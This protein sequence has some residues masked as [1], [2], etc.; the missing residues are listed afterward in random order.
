[1]KIKNII[2]ISALI[3]S[4][5]IILALFT[6]YGNKKV[7]PDLNAMML[8]KFMERNN[9]G[10]FSQKEF[11]KYSFF[12]EQ[13]SKLKGLGVIKEGLFSPNDVAAA[14]VVG[15]VGAVIDYNRGMNIYCEEGSAEMT[16]QGWIAHGGL[17]ADVPEVPASLRHFYD[18]TRNA[19]DRY[20][21]DIANS[22]LMGSLQKYALTNP[23]TDGVEWAI[24]QPGD[25][26]NDAQSHQFTWERGK[27]WMQMALQEPK[28]EK[29]NEYMAKAWRSLGETLHMIAD[30]GCP[31]HVRNDAHPS[32][33]LENDTWFGDADPYEELVDIIR[34]DDQETFVSFAS[35][36]PDADLKN[37]I[38]DMK[39]VRDLAHAL[40]EYTNK[41][42]V[43]NQTIAGIDKY[44]NRHKQIIHPEN[45]YDSPLLQQMTY[46]EDDYSYNSPSGIKQC[47]DHYYFAK[48]PVFCNPYVDVECVKSQASKLFPNIVE[49]GSKVIGLFIP[50]LKVEIK[51]VNGNSIKGNIIHT[52]D[53]EYQ[54]EIKYS[55]NLTLQLKNNK[56]KILQELNVQASNGKF[57]TSGISMSSEGAFLTAYIDFGGV[58]VQSDDFP[59]MPKIKEPEPVKAISG[60][61]YLNRVLIY[62]EGIFDNTLTCGGYTNS[63]KT[64]IDI[65]SHNIPISQGPGKFRGS[66]R[67]GNYFVEVSGT[68]TQDELLEFKYKGTGT[69]GCREQEWDIELRNIPRINKE[70]DSPNNAT[71]QLRPYNNIDW[72]SNNVNMADHVPRMV[73]K[74][75]SLE[76]KDQVRTLIETSW[77]RIVM[78]STVNISPKNQQSALEV[79]F[80]W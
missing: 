36:A 64:W 59:V 71:F 76:K 80:S 47:V 79:S 8:K 78:G 60:G 23:H 62:V 55:G 65:E 48:L 26:S 41:N 40:A 54:N 37:K 6:G 50:K 74:E 45:E 2:S 29:R 56:Y 61:A 38:K 73:L 24:G 17:A 22:K 28:V 15:D 77:G 9:K 35:G 11:R 42:F 27:L 14:G 57:E 1:M 67:F 13:E 68:F 33:V 63:E 30:N 44:G 25:R 21:T 72:K 19:G 20:L 66:K 43:T 7:H 46:N 16:P 39:K 34:R 58:R 12:F 10:D 31:P 69:L 51:S 75:T 4:A 52:K 53:P 49:V 3:I 32:P 5:I 70:T 18:P